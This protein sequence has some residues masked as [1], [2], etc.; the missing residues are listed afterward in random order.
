MR[1][2]KIKAEPNNTIVNTSETNL[3]KWIDK[4]LDEN[5]KITSI[6]IIE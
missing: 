5:Y 6:E 4:L 2:Y 1:R 3:I